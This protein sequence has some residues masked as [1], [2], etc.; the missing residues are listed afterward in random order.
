MRVLLCGLPLQAVAQ[1]TGISPRRLRLMIDRGAPLARAGRRG[2]GGDALIDLL[3]F[4]AW[5]QSAVDPNA[6]LADALPRILALPVEELLRRAKTPGEKGAIRAT[7][8]ACVGAARDAMGGLELDLTD[9][10]I[11]KIIDA[12]RNF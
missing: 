12:L 5:R 8:F 11:K 10:S 6:E 3:E 4:E 2:R 7:W 9:P 1:S